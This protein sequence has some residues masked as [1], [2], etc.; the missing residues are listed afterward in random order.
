M[1]LEQRIERLERENRRLKLAGG[2]VVAVLFG[3]ACVGAV[4]PRQIQDVIEAREFYEDDEDDNVRAAMSADAIRYLD[5]NGTVRVGLSEV[6]IGYW[7]ENGAIRATIHN[8]AI[9]Y[10][11]ENG[12]LAATMNSGGIGYLNDNGAVIA[13]ISTEGFVFYDAEGNQIWQAPR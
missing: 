3:A 1:D 10:R 9:D 6:G 5:E 4:I 11:H 7:D 8:G 2:A 13:G 12:S